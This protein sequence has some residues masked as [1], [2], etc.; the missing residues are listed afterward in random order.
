MLP[1]Y[2]TN[3]QLRQN[4]RLITQNTDCNLINQMHPQYTHAGIRK[5]GL[6]PNLTPIPISKH[7][8]VLVMR[9]GSHNVTDHQLPNNS[10]IP[11]AWTMQGQP[12]YKAPDQPRIT[13]MSAVP[14]SQPFLHHPSLKYATQ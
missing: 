14:G 1:V 4:G 8:S 6:P 5:T 7:N 3:D 13:H 10:H 2:S 12:I 11:H 9:T